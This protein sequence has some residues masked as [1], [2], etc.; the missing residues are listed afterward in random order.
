[1]NKVVPISSQPVFSW[2]AVFRGTVV[3]RVLIL[4][5]ILSPQLALAQLEEDLPSSLSGLTES[6]G[7]EVEDGGGLDLSDEIL[8]RML[9]RVAKVSQQNLESFSSYSSDVTLRTAAEA[10]R[11]YRFWVFELRGI[12]SGI[13]KLALP[14][15]DLDSLTSCYLVDLNSTEGESFRL[16]A[17]EIPKSW[18]KQNSSGQ[19]VECFGFYYGV[20]SS[21]QDE[22]TVPTFLA[23]RVQW[24]PTEENASLG[25]G[26]AQVLLA[27][28]GVDI[29]LLDFVRKQNTKSLGAADRDCF[30]QMLSASRNITQAEMPDGDLEFVNLM[31]NPTKHFSDN[32]VVEGRVRR[33]VPVQIDDP[34]TQELVG[35][36]SYYELD[37]F[38]QL[39]DQKIVVKSGPDQSLE[40]RQR[41]PITVCVAE[42]PNGLGIDDVQDKI[43]SVRGF[44]YR[45][46]KYQS[47]FTDKVEGQSGQVSPL[48]IGLAPEVVSPPAFVLDQFLM[49]SLLGMIVVV[50]ALMWF[51]RSP[52][53][54]SIAG[55]SP[56]RD[57]LPDSV[58]FTGVDSD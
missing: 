20:F 6:Q 8:I 47:E 34:P 53:R 9:Y 40:Y 45:F 1:M 33:C 51:F 12:V 55:H 49:Y 19:P 22:T 37:M 36:K 50:F 3:F 46:W 38:I 57:Q 25:V 18:S 21:S 14:N 4:G 52:K 26:P 27:S 54:V 7:A 56:T 2:M 41:F 31:K 42:L 32:V 48:I 10:P 11:D 13:E 23:N 39:G 44:F 30:F 16:V 28:K 29:G 24:R 35:L 5:V 43:V 17:R 15:A 58:D